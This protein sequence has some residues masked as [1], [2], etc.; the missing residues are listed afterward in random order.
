VAV[1]AVTLVTY[2]CIFLDYMLYN[3]GSKDDWDRYAQIAND[4]RWSWDSIQDKLRLVQSYR[5]PA[6]GSN[7]VGGSTSAWAK[8]LLILSRQNDAR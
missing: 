7:A 5:T 1:V 4:Q 6:D 2:V 3:T 8:Y